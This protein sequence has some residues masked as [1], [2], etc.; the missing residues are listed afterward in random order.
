[1]PDQLGSV[2]WRKR[3]EEARFMA[4][5]LKD[6]NAQRIML[7]IAKNYDQLG[8]QAAAMENAKAIPQ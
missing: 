3:A 2:Y 4:T 8:I 1:M 5:T 7:D 6:K